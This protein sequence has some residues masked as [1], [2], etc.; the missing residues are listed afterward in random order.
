[1]PANA[2]RAGNGVFAGASTIF[3]S[4]RRG[5]KGCCSP[6]YFSLPPIFARVLSSAMERRMSPLSPAE[7]ASCRYFW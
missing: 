1:M 2:T 3:Q 7:G 5:K 6:G 4:D